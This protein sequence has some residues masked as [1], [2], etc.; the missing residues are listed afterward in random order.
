V[1]KIEAILGVACELF[2]EKGFEHT[3]VSEIADRAGVAGGTIIYHFKTKDNLLHILTWQTLNA[4]Y[5]HSRQG[6]SESVDGLT[7]IMQFIDSF[8]AFLVSHKNECLLMLKNRPFEKMKGFTSGP[9]MDAF[10]LHRMYTEFLQNILKKGIEDRSMAQVPVRE[11][12]MGL[13]AGLIGAA[14]L[15]LFFNEDRE[16]LRQAIIASTRCRLAPAS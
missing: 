7:Q 3:P 8:F 2:A 10:T 16:A 12:A 15:H 6:V 5:K 9:D 14:W 4:L 13:F 11:T 1:D